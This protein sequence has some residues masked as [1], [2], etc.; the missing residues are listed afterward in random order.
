MMMYIIVELNV[1]LILELDTLFT[2]AT[3]LSHL[4]I[5]L[6]RTSIFVNE[7]L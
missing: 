4:V 7:L 2:V 6:T 1:M 3:S 5:Q